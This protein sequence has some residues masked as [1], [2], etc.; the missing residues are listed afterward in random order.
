MTDELENQFWRSLLEKMTS[1][2]A[3][4]ATIEEAQARIAELQRGI[5]LKRADIQQALAGMAAIVELAEKDG[6]PN[7]AALRADFDRILK[8]EDLLDRLRRQADLVV[9]PPKREA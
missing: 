3:E 5:D 7:A 4:G 9:G 2:E 1:G 6:L 8:D